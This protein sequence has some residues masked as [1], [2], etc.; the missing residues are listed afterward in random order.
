M[1][2]VVLYLHAIGAFSAF[3]DTTGA[4]VLRGIVNRS[5]AIVEVDTCRDAVRVHDG[6]RL[7]QGQRVVLF[8]TFGSN[9]QPMWTNVDTTEGRW[10]YLSTS[11]QTTLDVSKG[12]QLVTA[13]S[14]RSAVIDSVITCASWDGQRG[15]IIAIECADTLFVNN[16]IDASARGF[17]GG[18]PG[19]ARADRSHGDTMP[20]PFLNQSGEGV[21]RLAARK[22]VD[23]ATVSQGGGRGGA[24]NGGGGGGGGASAGGQGGPQC[25]AFEGPYV[26]GGGGQL[27]ALDDTIVEA[28]FGGGGGAGHQND[29]SNSRGGNGGG[30]VLL[31]ARV[32]VAD[33][34]SAVRANGEHAT[35]VIDDGAGGGGAGGTVVFDMDTII[36]MLSVEVIGGNGGNASGRLY[37]YGSGGDGAL[38]RVVLTLPSLS[39]GMQTGVREVLVREPSSVQFHRGRARVASV[40]TNPI[41]ANEVAKIVVGMDTITTQPLTKTSW[42]SVKMESIGGCIYTDSVQVRVRNIE[43][44]ALRADTTITI[45]D[46]IVLSLPT[47]YTQVLWNNGES[48][49]RIVIRDSG[50][51]WVRVVD[52]SGCLLRSD[53]MH[54]SVTARRPR[55]FVSVDDA[56]GRPGDNAHI[57][58]RAHTTDTRTKAVRITGV[59]SSRLS[60]LVPSSRGYGRTKTQSFVPVALTIGADDAMPVW[61]GSSSQSLVYRC[62]LGDSD[63]S[64]LVIDSV[65]AIGADVIVERRGVFRL[66]GVCRE[67]GATRL[68]DPWG[69]VLNAERVDELTLRVTTD[70]SVVGVFD[71]LGKR[72][73]VFSRVESRATLLTFATVPAREIYLTLKSAGTVRTMVLWMR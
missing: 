23:K 22:R 39:G 5:Y 44:L 41:C 25:S 11:I 70:A 52:T 30:I 54:V 73:D 50:W 59:L 7:V 10:V 13:P 16:K 33:T 64:D 47:I 46:S 2:F 29:H 72:L 9:R 15:G 67:G 19:A 56:S 26:G 51:F 37:N 1:M 18:Q 17:R 3:A 58:V 27:V 24:R 6:V 40:V 68:F 4:T 35:S 57:V 32:L 71:L 53:S 20:S 14:V 48:T 61:T 63:T 31:H 36:G 8:Q 60:L 55:I 42:I 65:Q 66:E 43:G 69:G 38:G 12:V 28:V 62:A 34:A 49:H 21:E 45:G